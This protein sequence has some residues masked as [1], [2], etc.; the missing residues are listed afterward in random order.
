MK[1]DFIFIIG[2]TSS[3]V[4]AAFVV[5]WINKYRRLKILEMKNKEKGNE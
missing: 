1:E 2:M 3:A 4:A 5:K